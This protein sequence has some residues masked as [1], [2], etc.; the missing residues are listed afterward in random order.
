MHS[1]RP[2]AGEFPSTPDSWRSRRRLSGALHFLVAGPWVAHVQT[3]PA[4]PKNC[5]IFFARRKI[6]VLFFYD[7]ELGMSWHRRRNH[8]GPYWVFFGMWMLLTSCGLVGIVL[9]R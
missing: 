6:S 2:R 5:R 9:S 1:L 7:E 3:T 4:N 8:T